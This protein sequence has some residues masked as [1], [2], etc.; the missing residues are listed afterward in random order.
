[1]DFSSWK[2][3]TAQD[4]SSSWKSSSV[5]AACN[6]RASTPDFWL[7]ANTSSGARVDAS[8]H[9]TF[10]VTAYSLGGLTG[11]IALKADLSAVRGLTGSFSPSSISTTGATVLTVTAGSAVAP[12]TYPITILGNLG[13]ITRT[14]TL[15]LVVP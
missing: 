1:M 9:A 10:A 6:L 14:V 3:T 15:S 8:R 13:N 2:L 4:A 7:V 11:N 12:G 5:P